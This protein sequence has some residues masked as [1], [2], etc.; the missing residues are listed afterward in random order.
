MPASELPAYVLEYTL[1]REIN[2]RLSY[3]AV[4]DPNFNPPG[5]PDPL[6]GVQELAPAAQP[7]A[8]GTPLLNFNGQGYTGVNPP[9]TVG[10]V[11]PNHYVQMING[12]GGAL[13]Q[14]Y[15]KATGAPI[16]SQFALESLAT[17]VNCQSGAG[18]P[19]VVYDN[20]AD[21][22]LLS[23]FASS[24]NHLC[25]YVSI[26]ANPGGTY[27]FYDF[28]TPTFPDYPKYAVWPDAYYVSSNE[29]N[30]TAY[31]LNRTRMLSGL[32]AT[33][34]RFIAPSLSG[35]GFQSLTPADLDG[36]TPPPAGAPGLFMRQR[37]TEVHGPAGYPSQDILETYAFHVDWTT[38]ANSTFTKQS[39]ILTA[40][41]DSTLCGLTSFSCIPQPGT[42]VRLDPLREVVMW[43]LGYRNFGS[44]EVLVG[45]FVTDVN[46]SDRAGVRWF[47][48]RKTGTAW[49]LYQEGTYAP[50]TT[51][52]WMGGIAMDGA[53][54]IALGY[55]VSSSSDYPGVRYAGRLASDALGTLP[56]GEHMLVNGTVSNANNRYGDYSAMSVDPADDCTFWFTGEW[57]AAG[58]WSTRIGKFKFDQCGQVSMQPRAYLPL[59][60]KS[61]ARTPVTITQ[62]QSQAIVQD[63]SVACLTAAGTAV[64][65]Y[66]RQFTLT[67]FGISGPFNVSSVSFGIEAAGSGS[68]SGQPLTVR[69]YRKINPAG[70]LT[71]AN[72]LQIGTATR[73]I[74][75]QALTLY[76]MPVAGIAPAGSVLVVE[77]YS[78]NGQ[79]SGDFFFVGSN[80]AGQTG[81][82]YL[83]SAACSVPEPTD[84]GALGFPGMHIVMNVTGTT[85][86]DLE[87]CVTM[88]DTAGA[89]GGIA[90]TRCTV[91]VEFQHRDLAG[92]GATQ[93]G[94][95][96]W[97]PVPVDDAQRY[98]ERVVP[99]TGTRYRAL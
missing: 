72:L 75:D 83:A 15:N 91:G 37:D 8:F 41:F 13:V 38:P 46:G 97:Q 90:S 86:T 74:S 6:L 36:A 3:N 24:G 52:R 92:D 12:G 27:Y 73:T 89:T 42:S 56:Q 43:R 48:L 71:Y 82:S 33:F 39:D 80:S 40:E 66:L 88:G 59:I 99:P 14:I 77:V 78:P 29:T 26:G 70:A 34:Q 35:F 45:N 62:S 30:P 16:G 47:E 7:N 67:S 23:E 49:T 94:Y 54:N 20:L 51:N 4:V 44:R 5:G 61:V 10:D 32:S 55:N 81:L 57:N 22:W 68:G 19:I 21:R 50:G 69:L 11:G 93:C 84:T 17:S 2:P 18:D 65:A 1:D 9:D 95:A 58:T 85:S 79:P 96:G 76:S 31:A 25:V 64:N 60:R 53:G 28:T 87:D 63:N 98:R